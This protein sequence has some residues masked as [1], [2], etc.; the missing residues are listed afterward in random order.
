M[1]G[2]FKK[3]KKREQFVKQS[4]AE[5]DKGVRDGIAHYLGRERLTE[6]RAMRVG[7]LPDE[8][9]AHIWQHVRDNGYFFDSEKKEYLEIEEVRNLDPQLQQGLR[10]ALKR[11]LDELLSQRK[12]SELPERMQ[13]SIESYL[14]QQDYFLDQ[15]R[16]AH[17]VASKAEELEPEIYATACQYLGQ[18]SLAEIDGQRFSELDHGLRQEIEKY[19]EGSDYFLDKAEREKFLQRRLADLDGELFEGLLESL[20]REMAQGVV[21]QQVAELDES[22]REL[23]RGFLDSIGYFVDQDALARF[24]EGMLTDLNLDKGDY[25]ALASWL[26]ERALR[27]KAGQRFTDLEEGLRRNIERYLGSTGY[28]LNAQKLQHFREQSFAD[29]DEDTQADL[30]ESLWRGREEAIRGKRLAELDEQTRQSVERFLEQKAVNLGEV[31]VAEFKGR[32]LGDLDEQFRQGLAR[33]LGHQRLNQIKD[34]KIA[35]LDEPDQTALESY[36]GRRLMHQIEQ[37]L[38]LGFISRLWVDY[39]TAIEDL[40]QGIGLQAYGQMDPLV[41]YKRRAFRMFGELNDNIRRMV[42]SNVFRYPPEPLKLGQ[43]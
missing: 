13:A 41:E 30:L 22:D 17:F 36:L 23:L 4:L 28:F 12:V 7:D 16:M 6:F 19:L 20:G 14:D 26:G 35:E 27:E 9:R 32:V 24:E 3:K 25:E 40:R 5:L 10:S 34:V 1:E 21:D 37:R 15:D 31:G 39:L 33:Y 29:L 8:L 42:V 38:M 11:G 18:R 2:L 43:E